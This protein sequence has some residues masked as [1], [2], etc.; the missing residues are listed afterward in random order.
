MSFDYVRRVLMPDLPVTGLPHLLLV[1]LASHANEAGE[2][3]RSV[4]RMALQA[5]CS[6]RRVQSSLRQLEQLKLIH[7][8]GGG[9]NGCNVYRLTLPPPPTGDASVT[10]TT[11]PARRPRGKSSFHAE[12]R[13][14]ASVTPG[15]APVTPTPASPPV[16]PASAG[17]DAGVPHGATPAS[18][19]ASGSLKEAEDA[20]EAAT[21]RSG[22]QDRDDSPEARWTAVLAAHEAG[23]GPWLTFKGDDLRGEWLAVTHGQDA[24]EVRVSLA[25]WRPNLPSTY[26]ERIGAETSASAAERQRQ[27]RDRD[28][29]RQAREHEQRLDEARRKLAA[30]EETLRPVLPRLIAWLRSGTDDARD[31]A[32]L[33]AASSRTR[34]ALDLVRASNPYG[35]KQLRQ[36][37]DGRAKALLEQA[38]AEITA[39]AT[40]AS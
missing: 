16:T 39:A 14:D 38:I 6:D 37:L 9:P 18:P 40:A 29:D 7:V 4:P 10:P 2:C 36:L 33:I 35:V 32:S 24:R 17:G 13:G 27:A 12:P 20:R 15:D 5:R 30:A 1:I 22:D 19:E 23:D 21:A 31:L 25:Q 28:L 3:Y 34:T 8:R 11:R 26:A